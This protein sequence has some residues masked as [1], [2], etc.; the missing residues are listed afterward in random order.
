MYAA[1]NAILSFSAALVLHE[2]G[3][4]F[5]ARACKVPVTEAGLGWGPSI[6]ARRLHPNGHGHFAEAPAV[7]TVVR[8][9]RRHR[10]EYHSGRRDLGH[11]LWCSQFG[12]GTG[13]PLSFIPT[14][15]MEE[16]HGNFPSRP[17]T[18]QPARGMVFHAL[19]RSGR[20]VSAH[21]RYLLLAG[22]LIDSGPT[23]KL[24][25]SEPRPP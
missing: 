6:A 23:A 24:L 4:F 12:T 13:K 20:I 11:F 14:R 10:S 25:H 21:T 19:S 3:H 8:A 15:R 17:Q 18:A 9:A 22:H 7:S 16:R 1:I 2:M 5:A